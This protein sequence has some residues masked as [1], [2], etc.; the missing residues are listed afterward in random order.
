MHNVCC[1]M[2]L[3]SNDI[4]ILLHPLGSPF[5]AMLYVN[6]AHLFPVQCFFGN[7]LKPEHAVNII[8]TTCAL[9]ECI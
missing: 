9:N 4:N 8:N 7:T 6:V 5:A 3:C 1:A 2:G